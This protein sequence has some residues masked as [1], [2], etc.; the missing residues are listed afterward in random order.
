MSRPRFCFDENFNGRILRGLT[1]RIPRDDRDWTT[2]AE[3]GLLETPDPELLEMA[4]A[5]GYAIVTHDVNTM[6]GHALEL[7]RAGR[8]MA[9]VILV[10]QSLEVG[11]ALE[12]L[13]VVLQA[14]S[15]EDL[16]DGILYL[17]L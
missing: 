4:A 5:E 13:A 7:V 15:A 12:D 8:P 2:V 9:G 11:R 3:L 6:I 10:P 16:R 1:R 14:S 17:P